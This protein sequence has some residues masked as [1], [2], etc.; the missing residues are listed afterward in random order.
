[1]WGRVL[2]MC[3]LP[4]RAGALIEVAG[5]PVLL[6]FCAWRRDVRCQDPPQ[7]LSP[8]SKWLQQF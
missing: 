6:H 4:S 8:I 2:G 5:M 7:Q 1:M 3:L